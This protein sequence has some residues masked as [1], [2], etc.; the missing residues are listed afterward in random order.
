MYIDTK[1]KSHA[2][3]EILIGPTRIA[4]I[5]GVSR[6]RNL[7]VAEALYSTTQLLRVS[8]HQHVAEVSASEGW[9]ILRSFLHE[10][11]DIQQTLYDRR[12]LFPL[13]I[14]LDT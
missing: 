6:C 10:Q 13:F 12:V 4:Q 7:V 11:E 14:R 2:S 1:A 3:I 5:L 8:L 9:M